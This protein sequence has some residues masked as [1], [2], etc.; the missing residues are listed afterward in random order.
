MTLTPKNPA[1]AQ[2]RPTAGRPSTTSTTRST[3][4]SGFQL[5]LHNKNKNGRPTGKMKML[6]AAGALRVAMPG[7]LLCSSPPG[8]VQAVNVE[9]ISKTRQESQ[10]QGNANGNVGNGNAGK[11]NAPP[12]ARAGTSSQTTEGCSCSGGGC[13]SQENTAEQ[14]RQKK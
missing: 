4:G 6:F 11:T 13:G 9:K 3:S 1:A 8:L 12:A 10:P 14:L 7:T 2:R 5:F